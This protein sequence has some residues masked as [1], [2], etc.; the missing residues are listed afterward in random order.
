MKQLKDNDTHSQLINLEKKWAMIE[1]INFTLK[2]FNAQKKAESDY[3]PIKKQAMKIVV[4]YNKVL[5]EV[6]ASG[7]IIG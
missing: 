6:I 2:E 3:I 5:Q 1:Q 4:E 7:G